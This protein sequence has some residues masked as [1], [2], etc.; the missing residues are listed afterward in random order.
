MYTRMCTD[1]TTCKSGLKPTMLASS[2]QAVVACNVTAP[3]V[4]TLVLSLCPACIV[5]LVKLSRKLKSHVLCD[6]IG[7]SRCSTDGKYCEV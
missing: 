3:R 6:N 4:C 7:N 5:S 2:V 1:L